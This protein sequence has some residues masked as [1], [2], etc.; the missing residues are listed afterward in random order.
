MQEE[1]GTSYLQGTK[2]R[3]T[4]YYAKVPI[5]ILKFSIPT[6]V[7]WGQPAPIIVK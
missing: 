5:G 6:G 4:T 7:F 3:L 2:Y 1:E